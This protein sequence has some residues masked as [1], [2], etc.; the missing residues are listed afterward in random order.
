MEKVFFISPY[1]P[2]ELIEAAGLQPIRILPD[3]IKN[4]NASCP[5]EGVCP[6]CHLAMENF[7][8]DKKFENIVLATTCDQN[9]RAAEFYF[10][11]SK[12]RIFLMNVPST[13]QT[14][15][16]IDIYGYELKRFWN[17][18]LRIANK[19]VGTEAEENISKIICRDFKA[20]SQIGQ[21]TSISSNNFFKNGFFDFDFNSLLK[22]RKTSRIGKKIPL[23]LLGE[24]LTVQ[25]LGIFDFLE[26]GGGFVSLDTT[27]SG[28]RAFPTQHDNIRS[29]DNPFDFIAFRNL[30]FI[31]DISQRPNT[32][33]FDWLKDKIQR[34]G[35]RGIILFAYLWCDM[36]RAERLRIKEFLDIPLLFLDFDENFK[37]DERS[38]GKIMSFMEMLR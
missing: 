17:F 27:F 16:S 12:K 22:K 15:T 18:L 9:R 33:I 25:H 3:S 37:T 6:F 2:Y 24:S 13:Y 34:C 7:L 1:I 38:M 11:G 31:H 23:A 30:N 4:R 21:E 8:D 32:K 36:W 5:K 19:D 35:I 10:Q 29:G 28:G 14:Q 20:I 26:S